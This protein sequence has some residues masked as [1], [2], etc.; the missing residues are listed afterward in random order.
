MGWSD[1][2][3]RRLVSGIVAEAM[4][5]CGLQD[6][7]WPQTTA[8]MRNLKILKHED[9]TC[10][11]LIIWAGCLDFTGSHAVVSHQTAS[12]M[13]QCLLQHAECLLVSPSC[14]HLAGTYRDEQVRRSLR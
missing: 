2:D 7:L 6:T 9:W 8:V 5:K 1:G 10:A 11:C 14:T 3:Q 4:G 13:L 12:T